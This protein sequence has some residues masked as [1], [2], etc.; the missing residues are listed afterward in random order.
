MVTA[1]VDLWVDLRLDLRHSYSSEG[2]MME[3]DGENSKKSILLVDDDRKLCELTKDYLEAFGWQVSMRHD[4]ESG[5]AEA[6]AGNYQAV[7]LDVMMPKMDGLEVLRRLRVESDVPVLMMTALGDDAD[8]IAG[9]ELGADDYLPKS[10]SAR[11]LLARLRAVT[12]RSSLTKTQRV[13]VAL[14]TAESSEPVP[15]IAGGLKVL[16][17]RR[18]AFLDAQSLELTGLEFNIL[19]TLMRANGVV[20]SREDLVNSLLDRSFT[21]LGRSIDVHVSQLRKKLGDDPRNPKFIQ[22]VRGVGY[23]FLVKLEQAK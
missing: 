6:L 11:E 5:L 1:G 15:L 18:E 23:K 22:T 2:G 16:I 13:R 17:D 3:V 7:I 19:V 10:F 12:R 8:R 21:E 20:K 14:G 9:L 4:G